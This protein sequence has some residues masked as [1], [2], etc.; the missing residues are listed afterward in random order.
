MISY[1]L[2]FLTTNFRN[3]WWFTN[4]SSLSFLIDSPWMFHGHVNLNISR[5]DYIIFSAKAVSLFIFSIPANCTASSQEFKFRNLQVTQYTSVHLNN[6][7]SPQ[8]L[9]LIGY[10]VL[11]IS[12]LK[13]I[14]N[15][16]P[17]LWP[18]VTILLVQTFTALCLD[19]CSNITISLPAVIYWS[20]IL[21]P[22]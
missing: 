10:E 18:S 8:S 9:H 7:C 20:F 6:L 14:S 4:I 3:W 17:S 1:I 12:P 21:Q 19:N 15:F 13:Y 11:L 16:S 2:I 22:K 5:T